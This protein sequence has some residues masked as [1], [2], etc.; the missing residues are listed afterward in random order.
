MSRCS[1]SWRGMKGDPVARFWARVDRRSEDECWEI[2]GKALPTGHVQFWADGRRYGAHVYSFRL[3][4]NVV[5]SGKMVCHKCNN[6]RCVN[7]K[8]LYAG[9]AQDNARDSIAA[10][11][12]RFHRPGAGAQHCNAKLTE[13]D[14]W[15]IRE[16]RYFGASYRELARKYGVS[17]ANIGKILKGETWACLTV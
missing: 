2:A 13:D 1:V 6:P 12:F 3:A 5:P 15:R 9:T 11:T 16:D 10:G 7:P 14:V 4:G 17:P 8:H